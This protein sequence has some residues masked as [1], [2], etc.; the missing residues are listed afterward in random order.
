MQKSNETDFRKR[1]KTKSRTCGL[2]ILF[3][4]LHHTFRAISSVIDFKKNCNLLC[5]IPLEFNNNGNN[6]YIYKFISN[7]FLSFLPP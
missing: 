2:H 1:N 7:L 6:R 5:N 4:C 3:T